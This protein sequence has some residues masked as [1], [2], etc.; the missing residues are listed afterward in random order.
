M[1]TFT[2]GLP[3]IHGGMMYIL[4]RFLT[5][6]G[7]QKLFDFLNLLNCGTPD[8]EIGE[9]LF[10]GMPRQHVGR[11]KWLFFQRVWILRDEVAEQMEDVVNARKDYE[12]MTE[13]QLKRAKILRLDVER[14]VSGSQK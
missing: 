2:P 11:Y 6:W 4:A 3:S 14:K 7:E 10:K 12:T 13:Q 1:R 8:R 5:K 9:R